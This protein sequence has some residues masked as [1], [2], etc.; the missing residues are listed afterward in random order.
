MTDDPKAQ[1]AGQAAKPDVPQPLQTGQSA[2]TNHPKPLQ[3]DQT[4]TKILNALQ[5][6]QAAMTDDPKP[7]DISRHKQD[8]TA[9]TRTQGITSKPNCIADDPK[10]L[11]AGQDAITDESQPLQTTNQTAITNH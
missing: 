7:T 1:Q 4:I 9:M 3:T 8:Q 2:I 11:H 5:T 10:A 6:G